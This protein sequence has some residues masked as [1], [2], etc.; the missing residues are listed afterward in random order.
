MSMPR[1]PM[2]IK[3]ITIRQPW[4]WLI[5]AGHK[6]IENRSWQTG[7]QG[8]ALIHAGKSLDE[9]GVAFMKKM[10]IAAPER[11]DLGGIIG[12]VEIVGCVS[13]S[14][15]RWFFGPFGFVLRD[16]ISIPFFPC[17]GALSFWNFDETLLATSQP[18]QTTHPAPALAS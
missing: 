18:N 1:E 15:S 5:I 2:M 14:A 8:R 6:D 13:K 10:G 16:P 3:A 17:R 7:F 9:S 4:A 11:F 12:S